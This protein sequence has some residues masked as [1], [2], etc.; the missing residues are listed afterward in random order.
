M[1]NTS[2]EVLN[3]A[4]DNTLSAFA[5]TITELKKILDEGATAAIKWLESNEMIANQDK[6]KVIVLKK[7]S[8][9]TDN[10]NI[11]VGNMEIKPSASVKLLGLDIDENLNFIKHIKKMCKKASAKLNAIKRLSFYLSE[12]DK[13]LL[14]EAHV[15]SHF[16]YS[17]TVWHFCGLVE[18]HKMEKLHER[19]IR[20]IYNEYNKSYFDLLE[21]KT[22]TTLYGKRTLA[23]CCETFK[24]VNG[25]NASYMKDIFTN[26]PSKYPSRNEENLYIPKVNQVTYGY[27]SYRV[28]GPKI[29][30]FLPNEIKELKSY[31]A[32][33][34]KI[35]DLAMPFCSCKNCL[36][37]QKQTCSSSILI[38]KMLQ[39]ILNNNL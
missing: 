5:N 7:P 6:F 21:E 9:E 12:K 17:S 13:K 32:F 2:V 22:L 25:L 16:N 36:I 28:Q 23:M 24:T 10:I 30:N 20:F 34:T 19:C 11:T 35:N 29:W 27:K 1:E 38:D 3:F 4:D 26:R 37:S 33:K 8:I 15:I 31:D 14:V 18:V 39:D